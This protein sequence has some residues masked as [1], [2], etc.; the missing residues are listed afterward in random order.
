M[1]LLYWERA[2]IGSQIRPRKIP[3]KLQNLIC[4]PLC[5]GHSLKGIVPD[6]DELRTQKCVYFFKHQLKHVF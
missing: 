3:D 6:K 4:R 1:S 5:C 2:I